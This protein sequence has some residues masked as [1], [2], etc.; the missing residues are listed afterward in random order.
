M[1]LRD[2]VFDPAFTPRVGLSREHVHQLAR[3][4]HN[5]GDL[6]PIAVWI[7]ADSK[8]PVILD[9]RHRVAAYRLQKIG[10]IPARVFQGDRKAALLE[11]A[12]ENAKATYS[13]TTS[14]CT[15]YAW[16]LVIAVAGSKREIAQAANVRTSTVGN[17][18]KRLADMRSAGG[19]PTGN[20]WRDRND[21]PAAALPEVEDDAAR[22]ARI[23]KLRDYLNG[24]ETRFKMEFGRKPTMEELG[25]AMRWH[26]GQPR[27]KAMLS[28]GYTADEDEFSDHP[29]AH[30]LAAPPAQPDEDF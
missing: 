30:P 11:A 10:D 3:A 25:V 28:G 22:K 12:R 16:G 20:W 15:Q 29:E 14:E 6:D 1:T 8:K 4:L 21:K 27:F 18:R 13:W 26:L 9:G 2:L 24:T 17:M 23:D 7:D 5:S 19:T